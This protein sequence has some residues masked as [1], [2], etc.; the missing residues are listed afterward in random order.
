MIATSFV[1]SAAQEFFCANEY[2]ADILHDALHLL[3]PFDPTK[4][5]AVASVGLRMVPDKGHA[6]IVICVVDPHK[7]SWCHEGL[8]HMILSAERRYLEIKGYQFCP[9]D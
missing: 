4:V 9:I 5:D 8:V 1:H 7:P 2:N 6:I 3:L